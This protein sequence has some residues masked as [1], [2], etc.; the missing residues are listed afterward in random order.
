MTYLDILEKLKEFPFVDMQQ[1]FVINI[2]E[3]N[4]YYIKFYDDTIFVYKYLNDERKAWYKT[5][6][7]DQYMSEENLLLALEDLLQEFS[8]DSILK[9]VNDK[10]TII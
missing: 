9:K 5:W 2:Y 4:A 6:K 1:R 8:K 7:F 10:H 3:N